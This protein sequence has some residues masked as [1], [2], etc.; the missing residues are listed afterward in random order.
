[1]NCTNPMCKYGQDQNCCNPIHE[2]E[3]KI[4]E[5]R[6]KGTQKMRPYIPGENLTKVSVSVEDTPEHGG[7]I[8]IGADNDAHWYVSKTFFDEN[9]VEVK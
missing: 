8:A 5:Y 2:T 9:Y 1:M 7:M 4:K 3:N 6:K